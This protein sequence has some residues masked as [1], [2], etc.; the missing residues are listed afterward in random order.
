MTLAFRATLSF[1]KVAFSSRVLSATS[2]RVTITSLITATLSSAA[3]NIAQ[4]QRAE[5]EVLSGESI[6]GQSFALQDGW[7]QVIGA[8]RTLANGV[9]FSDLD[10]DGR[11]EVI[12][13][14]TNGILAVWDASG[15]MLPGWP[16]T[17][18]AS[19]RSKPAIVDLD[20]DGRQEIV[21]A[22]STLISGG[23]AAFHLDGSRV[24]GWPR[25]T[26]VIDGFVSPTA[27]DLDLDG[28]PEVIMPAREKLY[29]WDRSGNLL[30]GFP[31]DPPGGTLG[32]VAVGDI[33]GGPEPEIVQV[34]TD[35]FNLAYVFQND[36][37]VADGWPAF[38][39]ERHAFAA[40]V[41]ADLDADGR[42][43]ILISSYDPVGSRG[44]L[45]GFEH[46][47]EP[48]Q[49]Y[50][51]EVNALQSYA[52]PV[53]GDMNNDGHLEILLPIK[54]SF[55]FSFWAFSAD[56][57]PLP[58]W[59]VSAQSNL[60]GS[61]I[62]INLDDDDDL[63]TLVADN[64]T[65][66]DIFAYNL[67]GTEVPGFP[68]AKFGAC[69]PSSGASGDID[70]DGDIEYGINTDGT[71]AIWDLD[72]RALPSGWPTAF[73]DNWNTNDASFVIPGETASVPGDVV[74][75][76]SRVRIQWAQPTSRNSVTVSWTGTNRLQSLL[77]V[78][79]RGRS[80]GRVVPSVSERE[81]GE[82]VWKSRYETV[83]SGVYFVVPFDKEGA[84]TAER[85]VF[86]R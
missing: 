14:S 84:G 78:D 28:S 51:I 44:I 6:G 80:L 86:V 67:D 35:K 23:V 75:D 81:R 79:A 29:V 50:P 39:A 45:S 83:P 1:P 47:G 48:I 37:T 76:R 38:V 13:G 17:L 30:P 8:G 9:A 3:L 82:S 33:V 11:L 54:Y 12:A 52:T 36:G 64:F 53:V 41:I 61:A 43:E 18:V 32:T 16:R 68:L 70:G 20:G 77:V 31:V 56:G 7:P 26:S 46:T 15:E 21:A 55:F 25:T 49:G 24:E 72:A 19:I 69:G 5:P 27:R 59:P 4:A 58:G 74:A 40:P 66:G 22:F 2:F 65:P 85:V 62:L 71:I 63:E 73:H 10:G 57:Q 34:S 42:N 60:E